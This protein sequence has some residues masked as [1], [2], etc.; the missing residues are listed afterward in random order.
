VLQEPTDNL[1]LASI[2]EHSKKY[3]AETKI[4]LSENRRDFD[5]NPE[6]K[7]SLAD[8]SIDYFADA[9]KCLDWHQRRTISP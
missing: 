1:I 6:A 2:V 5:I 7:K 4:L 3:P 8:C 9:A